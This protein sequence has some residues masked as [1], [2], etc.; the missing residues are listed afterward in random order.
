MIAKSQN[1]F[2]DADS[3]RYPGVYI[4]ILKSILLQ[5]TQ[6]SATV[7]GKSPSFR[8]YE[9]LQDMAAVKFI[10]VSDDPQAADHRLTIEATKRL[11]EAQSNSGTHLY[12][13]HGGDTGYLGAKASLKRFADDNHIHASIIVIET[14]DQAQA[15]A[16][17]EGIELVVKRLP[18]AY[19]TSSV[20]AND[21]TTPPWSAK[22]LINRDDV[23]ATY[24][25]DICEKGFATLR[26]L[27]DPITIYIYRIN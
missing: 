11:M 6:V 22:P 19:G 16:F 27:A 23:R 14:F 24:I 4:P 13:V 12:I 8:P 3:D 25:C 10:A 18:P 17:K 2:R 15:E 21:A 20:P 26:S 1:F 5:E 9:N 7:I